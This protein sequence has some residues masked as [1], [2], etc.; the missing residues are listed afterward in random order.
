MFLPT[1]PSCQ[2]I[3][4]FFDWHVIVLVT[5]SLGFPEMDKNRNYIN[6]RIKSNFKKACET[7]RAEGHCE[8]VSEGCQEKSAAVPSNTVVSFFKLEKEKKLGVEGVQDT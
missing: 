4:F 5:D 1:G 7:K 6:S 2:S 3:F 8:S